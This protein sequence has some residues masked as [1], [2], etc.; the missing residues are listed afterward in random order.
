M[1]SIENTMNTIVVA[2]E[3]QLDYLFEDE[4]IDISTDI[5]VLENMLVQEGLTS[6]KF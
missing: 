6:G 1:E 2:F 4:A 3:N 5:T